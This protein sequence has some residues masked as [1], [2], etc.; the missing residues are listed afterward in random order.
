MTKF[1]DR[2]VAE[3]EKYSAGAELADR[4]L[5]LLLNDKN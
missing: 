3:F 5:F 1:R 2:L 4:L